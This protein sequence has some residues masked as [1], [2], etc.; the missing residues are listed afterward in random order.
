[1]DSGP[2][3]ALLELKPI[4]LDENGKFLNLQIV[5]NYS[6]MTPEMGH[7]NILLYEEMIFQLKRE[8]NYGQRRSGGHHICLD[9]SNKKEGEKGKKGKEK[10]KKGEYISIIYV[11][12]F[13]GI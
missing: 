5:C 7:F 6:D 8:K 13:I 4:R 2:L 10:T 12:P 11:I 1:M 3:C 9:T